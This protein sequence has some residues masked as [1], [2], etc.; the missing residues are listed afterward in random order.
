MINKLKPAAILTAAASALIM[1]SGVAQAAPAPTQIVNV[2]SAPSASTYVSF[3][4]VPWM[5]VKERKPPLTTELETHVKVRTNVRPHSPWDTE[6]KIYKWPS[7]SHDKAY[8]IKSHTFTI[9][10]LPRL[11]HTITWTVTIG[12]CLPGL[13]YTEW[14]TK[15]TNSIGQHQTKIAYWPWN[16]NKPEG[17]E[18]PTRTQS[19]HITC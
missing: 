9:H 7:L 6:L 19:K 12:T 15:G 2:P 14:I 13:Y 16:H 3:I 1:L 5:T 8:V 17:A 4:G 18:A 11:H 10:E